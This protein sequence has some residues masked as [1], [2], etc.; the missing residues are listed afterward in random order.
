VLPKKLS[1]E[2]GLRMMK[3][4]LLKIKKLRSSKE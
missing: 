4:N 2:M 1:S 3:K